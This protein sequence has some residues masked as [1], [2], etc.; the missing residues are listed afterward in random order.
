MRRRF[1]PFAIAGIIN[2]NDPSLDKPQR[3]ATEVAREILR[4][5][6]ALNVRGPSALFQHILPLL[7]ERAPGD[8]HAFAQCQSS[9][10]YFKCRKLPK[11]RLIAADL[12]PRRSPFDSHGDLELWQQRAL[13]FTC[14][15]LTQLV[16]K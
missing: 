4:S 14:L 10:A 5:K 9:L 16:F 11:S 1:A 8:G 2:I 6:M 3:R 12:K 7:Y 13:A 15:C